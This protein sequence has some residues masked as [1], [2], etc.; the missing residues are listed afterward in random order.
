VVATTID[1]IASYLEL[2]LAGLRLGQ[3]R[4]ATASHIG[5]A[6]RTLFD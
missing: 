2:A 4:V 3:G 6:M 1:G 5:S